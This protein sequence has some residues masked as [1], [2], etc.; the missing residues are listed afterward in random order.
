[1]VR[2][3][4]PA[5]ALPD[6]NRQIAEAATNQDAY[7]A[8]RAALKR[9][10]NDERN[11]PGPESVAKVLWRIVNTAKPPLRYTT[12]PTVQRAAVWLKR[13]APYAAVEYGM[14][15]YYGLGR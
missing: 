5:A 2:S 11:G 4:L 15:K 12:G 8:F 10:A 14:G 7:S 9:A 6:Q 13:M 3:D 1:M